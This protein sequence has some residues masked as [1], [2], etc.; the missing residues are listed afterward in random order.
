MS[1]SSAN[2]SQSEN[3]YFIDHESGAEMARLLDQDR[4]YTEAMGGFFSERS[5]LSTIHRMLDIGCGPG[6]W[7]QEVAYAYPDKEVV[8]IDISTAMISYA[9][10]QAGVQHLENARFLVMDATE[11]LTF[12]DQSFDLVNARLIAFLTPQQ[13]PS[14]IQECLRILRPGGI[15]RLTECQGPGITNSAAFEQQVSFFAQALYRAG[16]SY[17]PDGR[18]LG[19]VPMLS[20][21]LRRAGCQ[22]IGHRAHMIDFSAGEAAQALWSRDMKTFFK[23]LQPFFLATGVTTQEEADKLYTQMEI[24][25]L[26]DDF[27]G[28]H[29]FTT[30][31]GEKS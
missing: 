19:I 7:V 6:G 10:A 1:S 28:V 15:L 23:L 9:Q 31:W 18:Q 24:D 8:G 3:T 5:D 21:F 20:G 12:E 30:V 13:W 4:L 14:L 27:S 2:S 22:H 11:P 17:S 29:L 26:S 25:M 16:Q